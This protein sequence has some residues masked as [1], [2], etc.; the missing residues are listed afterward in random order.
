MR[1]SI[2][3]FFGNS[4]LSHWKDVTDSSYARRSNSKSWGIWCNIPLLLISLNIQ[5]DQDL[6]S[7]LSFFWIWHYVACSTGEHSLM[8]CLYWSKGCHE[9]TGISC[10]LWPVPQVLPSLA[11][12]PCSSSRQNDCQKSSIQWNWC[13]QNSSKGITVYRRLCKMTANRMLRMIWLCQT[14]HQLWHGKRL[15]PAWWS[16]VSVC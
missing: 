13:L 12:S 8:V 5:S 15:P 7:L 1:S 16:T 11:G 3:H 6:S 10:Y 2:F 9:Y 4:L 14:K